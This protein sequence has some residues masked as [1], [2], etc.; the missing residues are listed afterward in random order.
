M[1]GWWRRVE[2]KTSGQ[3]CTSSIASV[4]WGVEAKCRCR[5]R[6]SPGE[7]GDQEC[8]E[9]A[10]VGKIRRFTALSALATE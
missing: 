6:K 3:W 10:A 1:A 7:G 8:L 5:Q 2:Q 4:R 9:T